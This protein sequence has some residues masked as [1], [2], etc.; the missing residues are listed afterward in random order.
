MPAS[1]QLRLDPPLR[2]LSRLIVQYGRAQ[3]CEISV[4][5]PAHDRDDGREEEPGLDQDTTM[6][7]MHP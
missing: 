6:T 4:T 5:I 1:G 7:T 3:T 2:L